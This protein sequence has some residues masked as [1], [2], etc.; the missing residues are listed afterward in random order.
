MD[1]SIRRRPSRVTLSECDQLIPSTDSCSSSRLLASTI[2]REWTPHGKLSVPFVVHGLCPTIHVFR[3]FLRSF[4]FALSLH[5]VVVFSLL[6]PEFVL[7]FLSDSFSLSSLSRFFRLVQTISS[8]YLVFISNIGNERRFH[9]C[10][11]E[12]RSGEPY[13]HCACSSVILCRPG[14]SSGLP[15]RPTFHVGSSHRLGHSSS[16]GRILTKT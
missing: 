9:F 10:L 14:F 4:S 8:W 13:E 6:I 5:P 11:P 16:H 7:N 3:V 15:F 2:Y 12:Q 1:S